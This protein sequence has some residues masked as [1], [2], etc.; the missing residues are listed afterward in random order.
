M[1]TGIFIPEGLARSSIIGP[2]AKLAWG[3]L[4]RYA[5]EDGR[6]F[7]TVSTLAAEIGVRERQAQNYLGELETAKLIRRVSRFRGRAQDSN[8]YEFLW[9]EVFSQGVHD[10]AGGGVQDPSPRGVQDR[11]PKE[12]QDKESPDE[13]SQ[14]KRLR[15]SGH[16]LQKPQFAPG[17]N[18]PACKQY[19]KL[20]EALADYLHEPSDG[21]RIYPTDRHVV[22]V[23]DAAEGATEA[24]V[25]ACL[26]YLSEERGLKPGTRNGP[27][28]FSWFPTVVGDYF[29]QKRERQAASPTSRDFPNTRLSEAVF[30]DM[31]GAIGGAEWT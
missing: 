10:R 21:E 3:R 23:M 20:R 17:Q 4:A 26:R 5:G 15:L 13:E 2:G 25:L 31:T 30:D 6:C 7:P 11:A 29:R 8:A 16:E 18:T 24:E 28:S 19:P 22:D 27:R 1:F 9:H 14:E 12:S